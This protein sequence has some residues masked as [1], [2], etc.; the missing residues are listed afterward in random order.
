MPYPADKKAVLKPGFGGNVGK[1][2]H[3]QVVNP[4]AK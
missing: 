1:M 2:T 4:A 3:Y